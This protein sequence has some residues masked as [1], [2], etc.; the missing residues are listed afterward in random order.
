M[1]KVNSAMPNT[2]TIDV[3]TRRN[4]YVVTFASPSVA[5]QLRYLV[6]YQYSGSG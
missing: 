1:M 4:R 3:A 6:K 2:T 5:R